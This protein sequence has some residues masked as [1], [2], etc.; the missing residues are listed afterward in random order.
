MKKFRYLLISYISIF[1]LFPLIR[2]I[3]KKFY[4]KNILPQVINSSCN[5]KPIDYQRKKIIPQA[6]G[7]VLE[8]GIG[9][10]SNLKH[11]EQNNVKKII[12]V[13]PSTELNKIAI[14]RA[15]KHN[16]TVE[17]LIESA[18]NLSVP[19]NSIDTVV[20]TYALCS[21]P[22]PSMTLK[23][24]HRVLK[25]TGRFIFSEHGLA[26]DTSVSFIQNGIDFFYPKI[27]GGCHLNRYIAILLTQNSFK[28][29][30]LDYMYL[31]AT[32]KFLDYNSWLS[33]SI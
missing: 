33:V 20:S 22:N 25:P 4:D 3:N 30:K 26:P 8:I 29:A 18:D 7:L 10:G 15:E 31:P 2:L 16:L 17:F 23:E 27:A 13:D 6:K 21:I 32:Q 1:I 24:I 5:S 19:D 14:K 12:G 11:Y 28:I 9:P